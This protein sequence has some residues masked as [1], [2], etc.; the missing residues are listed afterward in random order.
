MTGIEYDNPATNST[1]STNLSKQSF[2]EHKT[3]AQY[4]CTELLF[5]NPLPIEES[6]KPAQN[7]TTKL[8]PSKLKST[9]HQKLP[10]SR[11]YC[12]VV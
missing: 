1:F 4:I 5:S 2:S 8:G 12:M 3:E 10:E 11:T 9:E 6:K 7:T